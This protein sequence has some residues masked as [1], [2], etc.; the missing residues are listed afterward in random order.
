M[1]RYGLLDAILAPSGG[2]RSRF[3]IPDDAPRILLTASGWL[4]R[5]ALWAI[6]AAICLWWGSVLWSLQQRPGK[7]ALSATTIDLQSGKRIDIG[8]AD[9]GQKPGAT[10]AEE[11]HIRF[12]AEN[13][14]LW[15]SNIAQARKLSLEFGA[16]SGGLLKA[17]AET[18]E[19]ASGKISTVQVQGA[20]IRFD[21]VRTIPGDGVS[22][23]MRVDT[24]GS[25]RSFTARQTALGAFEWR[26]ADGSPAVD[27]VKPQ[28][29]QAFRANAAR[30]G[31]DLSKSAVRIWDY[32]RS[33]LGYGPTAR[34]GRLSFDVALFGGERDCLD[35]RRMQVGGIAGLDWRSLKLSAYNGVLSVT[36]TEPAR[37]HTIP[38]RFSTSDARDVQLHSA[39]SYSAIKW[40]VDTD[41]PHGVLT[42]LTA[43]STGYAATI[44]K[45][46]SGYKISLTPVDSVILHDLRDPQ[47]ACSGKGDSKTLERCP[48]PLDTGCAATSAC[49]YLFGSGPPP[50]TELTC[51]SREADGQQP[52]DAVVCWSW[53]PRGNILNDSALREPT[54]KSDTLLRF[55]YCAAGAALALSLLLAI[56][57]FERANPLRELAP[58][59]LT[60][61]SCM[62]VLA[63]DLFQAA[64]RYFLINWAIFFATWL[65]AAW[66]LLRVE[67]GFMLW[68]VWIAATVLSAF[69]S[70]AMASMALD[71]GTSKWLVYAL[72]QKAIFLDFVPVFAI[73][74]AS[75]TPSGI[76]NAMEGYA[77][78]NWFFAKLR[79]LIAALLLGVF[80][81]WWLSQ[82]Q[83][84]LDEFQPV[85][86][87][88]F[89]V[90]L[91]T[92]QLLLA[93]D[94]RAGGTGSRW[95]RLTLFLFRSALFVAVLILAKLA[96]AGWTATIAASLAVT[97]VLSFF[98]QTAAYVLALLGFVAILILVPSSLKDWS[99]A[100]I[101][102]LVLIGLLISFGAMLIA[103]AI[104]FAARRFVDRKSV[105]RVFIPARPFR[106]SKLA[107]R[108]LACALAATAIFLGARW[109]YDLDLTSFQS[110]YTRVTS[111]G[112]WEADPDKRLLALERRG[113][114]AG[115]LVVV[116]RFIAWE[117]LHFNMTGAGD[118]SL[119]DAPRRA[120]VSRACYLD[121]ESQLL[122][123][124][125]VIAN[126]PDRFAPLLIP[127]AIRESGLASLAASTNA[128]ATPCMFGAAAGARGVAPRAIDVPVVEKDFA[129]TYLLAGLGQGAAFVVF[130]AQAL[131]IS[132]LI[133]NIGR[134]ILT[135]LDQGVPRLA[136]SRL[137]VV[138]MSGCVLLLA[139]QWILAWSNVLGI[140]PV[141][142]QPMTWIAYAN[143]HNALMAIPCLIV[144]IAGIRYANLAPFHYTPRVPQRRPRV[145]PFSF[146][147]KSTAARVGRE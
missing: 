34:G 27:C 114:A 147:R 52:G 31:E 73:A 46:G 97:V 100:L 80:V 18:Y 44:Q 107:Q 41:G 87:A 36:A 23:A 76:K 16:R 53:S 15:I 136:T 112:A 54:L 85:E 133:Y 121:S 70:I 12:V 90:V 137:L 135:G 89:A 110:Y 38:I 10:S 39:E 105:P 143:S 74:L 124:R 79:S 67:G 130:A 117:D 47:N 26:S 37:R 81:F 2:R 144:S 61:T 60:L 42:K 78:D 68:L 40:R 88:K 22:F 115:R 95:G 58:V 146:L 109:I 99:P 92:A 14:G 116:E 131:L 62:L 24:N 43:G 120:D 93:F 103:Q 7:A 57:G 64:D 138:A 1:R 56:A 50:S 106:R 48:H 145:W 6:V 94:A 142:G 59:L 11:D 119:E 91:V 21:D 127:A 69:A 25:A 71:G 30:F 126:A 82:R 33:V 29:L 19:I 4:A 77:G 139:L 123:S 13:G 118:C 35:G 63:P 96:F 28:G 84:G 108:G 65:L 101:M 8:W 86:F 141:M 66:L 75:A 140:F 51:E 132:T 83:T 102:T 45:T 128:V 113:L 72:K 17:N 129:G 98:G 3:A 5:A 104:G 55:R 134:L 111:I 125:C 32:G 122:R 20:A 9:L 49:A